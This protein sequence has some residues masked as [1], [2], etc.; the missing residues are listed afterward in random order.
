MP[1]G[2]HKSHR[3]FV[4]FMSEDGSQAPEELDERQAFP[5]N[6]CAPDMLLKIIIAA[7]LLA[8]ILI[9]SPV[10]R[11]EYQWSDWTLTSLFVQ[12]TALSCAATLCL[13]REWLGRFQPV[14]AAA[15]SCLIILIISGG[16]SEIAWRFVITPSTYADYEY[17]VRHLLFIFHN[18]TIALIAGIFMLRYFYMQ[19]QWRML[20]VSEA[21]A[22]I[23]ALQSR[24]NPHF[25]FNSM[26][27][28]AMLT[29]AD[30]EQAEHAIEDL[31]SLFR[32]A[33]MGTN[34]RIT[35]EEELTLCES[36][37]HIENWRFGERLQ[38]EWMVDTL[39]RD[40]LVPSLCLQPVLENAI[41]HGIQLIP[42]G[43]L[44]RITGLT[45]GEHIKIDV[46]NPLPPPDIVS[47]D[48]HHIGQDNLRRRLHAY[49]G[50]AGQLESQKQDTC[51]LVSLRFPYEKRQDL[52]N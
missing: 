43:G 4:K 13:V 35:L 18:G 10:G 7:Q 3:L 47:H 52:Q 36:Y 41:R 31:S 33:L 26:N 27:T 44:I 22:R 28:I 46:E 50:Q 29:R 48:G 20:L 9:L 49:F 39:P 34:Q 17:S 15:L 1:H 8:V 30:A 19:H 23:Q 45:D 21:Q 42:E 14:I 5:P 51:Y 12:V 2:A 40:A 16:L 25:L 38:V 24:I 37:L 32:A 11:I 6:F